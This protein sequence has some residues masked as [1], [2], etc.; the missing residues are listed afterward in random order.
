[1][2]ENKRIF[3]LDLLRTGAI[4][5]VVYGHG[6]YL[7]EGTSLGN[8]IPK[9][10]YNLPVFDGVS[11]FFV[12]SGFLI[13][14]IL[15]RTVLKENFNGRMLIEFWIRRWFRTLPNYFFILS[16]L[17]IYSFIFVNQPLEDQPVHLYR[18][19]SFTQ[20]L[21]SPHPN[22]FP[23]AWSLS[24]EEWFYLCIPIPLYFSTKLNN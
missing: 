18:Y 23:E 6:Y 24:V 13:G 14:R 11:I 16:I 7:I 3:G 10:I 9:E 17:V 21:T 15:L 1:M 20:N 19:F 2:S 5:C 8:L 22:F 4:F 12:L